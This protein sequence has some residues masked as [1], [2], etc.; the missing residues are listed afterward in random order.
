MGI[1]QV[2][3]SIKRSDSWSRTIY[4]QDENGSPYNITGWVIYFLIKPKIDD[5]DNAIG[6]IAAT[7]TIT[8]ATNGEATIELT[9][10]QTSVLG[11]YLFGCKVITPNMVGITHE[12]ITVL[13]GIINFTDR[14][15]QAV[16]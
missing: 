2:C 8:N 13:E 1:E 6:V 14:V 5:A 16:A 10:T 4:F 12:A 3:I 9:S 7:V 11:N 15:V